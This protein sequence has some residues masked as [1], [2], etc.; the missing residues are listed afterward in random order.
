M[1][2][3]CIRMPEKVFECFNKHSDALEKGFGLLR[4][5][6]SV[7]VEE[8]F[9]CLQT[10]SNTQESIR[11]L[12]GLLHGGYLDALKSIQICIEAIRILEDSIRMPAT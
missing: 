10:N 9:G 3:K 12:K 11:I 7:C 4:R 5:R 1:P 2:N 8:A 6:V